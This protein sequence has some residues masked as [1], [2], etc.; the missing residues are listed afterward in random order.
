[1][2][3]IG[4]YGGTNTHNEIVMGSGYYGLIGDSWLITV[5]SCALAYLDTLF[6]SW[7]RMATNNDIPFFGGKE[8]ISA[9]GVCQNGANEPEN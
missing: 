6:Q 8:K 1:M 2:K 3:T 5:F 9:V 7:Y 4:L